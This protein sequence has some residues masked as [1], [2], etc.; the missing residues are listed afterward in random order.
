[1]IRPN[2]AHLMRWP[3]SY[4][5][6]ALGVMAALSCRDALPSDPGSGSAGLVLQLSGA[7]SNVRTVRLG[8]SGPGIS[9]TMSFNFVLVSGTIYDTVVVPAGSDR[10]IRANAFDSVGTNT[11]RGDTTLTLLP[12]MN[13]TLHLAMRSL[14]ADLPIEIVFGDSL[15]WN[16]GFETYAVGSWPPA[17][18]PDG[19]ASNSSQNYVAGDVSHGGAHSLRL[20]GALGACWASIAYRSVAV[21]PPFEVEVAI[22]NGIESLSGCNPDRAALQLRKCCTWSN[23]ARMLVMFARGGVIRSGLGDSL[24]VFAPLTWYTVRIRYERTS[25][26]LITVHYWLNGTDLGSRA[27]APVAGED[28]LRHLELTVLEG[29]AWFDDVKVLR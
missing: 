3:F 17:W 23:P 21:T 29:S 22:R 28:S 5:V 1:M 7:P 16:D 12:G 25:P 14:D 4:L 19:N 13:G 27:S 18:T 9:D 15:N 26:S 20:F 8:V 2:E 6:C 11:H 10:H 24:A